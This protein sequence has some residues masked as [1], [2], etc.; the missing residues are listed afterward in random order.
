MAGHVSLRGALAAVC[1]LLI[2]GVGA[3]AEPFPFGQE[4]LLDAAPM[5]PGKR[6][7]ILTVEANGDV[8]RSRRHRRHVAGLGGALSGHAQR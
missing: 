1:L 3:A 6:M 5:R 7:P 2:C 8:R 4:L